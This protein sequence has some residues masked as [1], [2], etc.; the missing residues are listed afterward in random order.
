[1]TI[2]AGLPPTCVYAFGLAIPKHAYRPMAVVLVLGMLSG[3]VI[4]G[5]FILPPIMVLIGT[6]LG[7]VYLVLKY[8]FR[9]KPSR[10]EPQPVSEL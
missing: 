2:P 4:F 5:I 3:F 10:L 7:A 8:Y 6:V 9:R 1:M